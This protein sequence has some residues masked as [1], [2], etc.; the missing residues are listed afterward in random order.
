MQK[1]FIL[2]EV[3]PSILVPGQV[4]KIQA[5]TLVTKAKMWRKNVKPQKLS[6]KYANF[7]SQLNTVKHAEN[8]SYEALG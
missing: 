1:Y 5:R 2:N 6:K 8:R 4:P 3:I 7:P